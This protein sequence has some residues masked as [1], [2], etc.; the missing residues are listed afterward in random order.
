MKERAEN[1]N[2][3]TRLPGNNMIQEQVETRIHDKTPFAVV[4]ADLDNFKALNDYYGIGVGD[5]A[6]K[7][8][9][10]VLRQ[11]LKKGTASD[12]LGHEGGGEQL[13]SIELVPD[14][15]NGTIV[16]W[17]DPAG[18][19]S[20]FDAEGKPVPAVRRLLDGKMSV[21]AADV[22]WTGELRPAG[23]PT[24]GAAL[25][26]KFHKDV[27]L[28]A[29]YLG[30]NKSVMASRVNDVVTVL[31]W[32]QQR[33]K[34]VHLA[35]LRGA[36]PWALLG[37]IL[38]T[39]PVARA[40]IALDGFAFENLKSIDDEHLLPGALKYGGLPGLLPLLAGGET[41]I[42]GAPINLKTDAGTGVKAIPASVDPVTLVQTLL[43]ER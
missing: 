21:L 29:Y 17:M 37:R 42:Y 11:A 27:P 1:A 22:F 23:K 39:T 24:P 43:T 19:S 3:L 10:Q 41:A 8:T 26:Q 14:Q 18:K 6:I 5:R 34:V 15:W 25:V 12:F 33:G 20:V 35:A 36:G 9:A 2:P 4:Y 32:A 16:V 38:T 31:G 13:P 30:Y 40:A 28:A 7:L